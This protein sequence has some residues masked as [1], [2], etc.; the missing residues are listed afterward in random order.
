MPT[1]HPLEPVA[2][3]LGH[4]PVA[5]PPSFTNTLTGYLQLRAKSIST[6]YTK[7]GPIFRT[8]MR[9]PFFLAVPM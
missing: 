3:H 5:G 6:R 4:Q 9:P 7:R 2:Q 8:A 1:S